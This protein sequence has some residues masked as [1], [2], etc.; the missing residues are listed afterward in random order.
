MPL[1]AGLPVRIRS[2]G[3][4]GVICD[5][6]ATSVATS[7]IMS[8]VDSSCMTWPLSVRV[9]CSAEVS[10]TKAAGTRNGPVGR[11]PGAFLPRNQSVPISFMSR[12]K[13]RSRVVRSL[14]MV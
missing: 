6:A 13:T 4:S 5:A 12:R 14:T 10:P 11:K 3:S 7:K 1:P 2:P 9:S 8:L